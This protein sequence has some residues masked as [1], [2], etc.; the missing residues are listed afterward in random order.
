LR[1]SQATLDGFWDSLKEATWVDNL[2]RIDYASNKLRQLRIA[3][4]V[5][6]VIPQTL[7]TNK[8]EA[9]REFFGQ[10]NGKMVSK[11]LTALSRSMEANSSLPSR[12]AIAQWFFKSKFQSNRNYG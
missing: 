3:S 8:A 5:G 1:E 2:E 6:F 7:V 11:L 9:A 12:C 4:E 10:V